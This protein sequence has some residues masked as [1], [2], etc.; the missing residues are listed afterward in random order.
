M[1]HQNSVFHPPT[2]HIPW[3]A[4]DDAVSRHGS[5][6]RV[7]HLRTRDRFPALLYGQLSGAA[8]L[9]E[10]EDGLASQAARRVP[11]RRRRRSAAAA[12]T[13]TRPIATCCQ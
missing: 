2:K 8:S 7:R 1:R 10:T 13:I 4:F 12:A 3:A 9:R 11:Q 5:D 6:R